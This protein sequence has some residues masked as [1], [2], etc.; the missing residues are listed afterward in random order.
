MTR[1]LVVGRVAK[2]HGLRGEVIVS[3]TTNRTER[4]APGSVLQ[5]DRGP[6]EVV[7]YAAHQDRWRVQFAGITDRTAAESIHGLELRAEPIDD[8]DALWVHDLLGASVELTD[9]TVVGAVESVEANPASD[10]LVLDSGHLVPLVFVVERRD[11]VLVID[12]PLGL[13]DDA[14]AV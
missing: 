2:P 14:D 6:L 1:L 13:L 8:P 4:V 10:L 5:T 11:G 3:L 9:G 7:R 12:P